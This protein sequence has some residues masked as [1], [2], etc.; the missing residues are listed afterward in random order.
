[1]ILEP[2]L[3]TGQNLNG[4]IYQLQH[5]GQSRPKTCNRLGIITGGLLYMRLY[6]LLIGQLTG[7]PSLATLLRTPTKGL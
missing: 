7:T 2:H 1:M 4:I 5:L 3:H 6:R